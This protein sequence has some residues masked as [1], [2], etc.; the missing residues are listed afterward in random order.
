MIDEGVL[1]WFGHVERMEKDRTAKRVYVRERIG[2]CSIGRLRKRW[3][4]T[5][6]DFLRKRGLDVRQ[7]RRMVKDRSECRGFVR[8]SA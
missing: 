4:D 6:K 3:I 2:S 5:V 7:A 1:Q 8:G